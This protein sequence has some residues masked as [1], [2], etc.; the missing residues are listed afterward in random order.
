MDIYINKRQHKV[1]RLIAEYRT[2]KGTSFKEIKLKDI[3]PENKTRYLIT[4]LI[5]RPKPSA[6]IKDNV[7]YKVG[8][9]GH[10]VLRLSEDRYKLNTRPNGV[11]VKYKTNEAYIGVHYNGV[12]KTRAKWCL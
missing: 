11:Y 2:T 3:V 5:E 10:G 8:I 4:A 9:D 12:F 1:V 6:D 7:L